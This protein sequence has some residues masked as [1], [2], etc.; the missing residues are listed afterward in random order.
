MAKMRA[1]RYHRFTSSECDV[2]VKTSPRRLK[3]ILTGLAWMLIHRVAGFN[4][5][6]GLR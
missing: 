3:M 4:F 1:N 2:E 5:D 6:S